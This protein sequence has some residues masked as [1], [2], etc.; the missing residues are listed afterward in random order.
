MEN[1]KTQEHK[2][3]NELFA[4]YV[5]TLTEFKNHAILYIKENVDNTRPTQRMIDH[6]E[7]LIDSVD[8]EIKELVNAIK[9]NKITFAE[10]MAELNVNATMCSGLLEISLMSTNK[11]AI[12]KM[13]KS[14][15]AETLNS[16]K[17]E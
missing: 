14:V 11:V 17:H 9:A 3:V 2:I 12:L 16:L 10:Q 13:M 4:S 6:V 15:L 1:K 5:N 8:N 7:K